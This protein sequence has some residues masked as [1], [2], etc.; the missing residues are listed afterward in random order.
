MECTMGALDAVL[1]EA[2]SRFGISGSKVTTL[3]S[4]LL[5][6]VNEQGG[7]VGLNA[8]AEVTNIDPSCSMAYWGIALSRRTGR[9][10]TPC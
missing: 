3:L 6:F 1:N 8:F 7:S 5:S 9:I 2:G 10:K 4:S